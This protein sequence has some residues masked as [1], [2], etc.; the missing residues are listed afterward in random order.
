[1]PADP[2]LPSN[3]FKAAALFVVSL[4]D[5]EFDAVFL[6]LPF[7]TKKHSSVMCFPLSRPLALFKWYPSNSLSRF[8]ASSALNYTPT[9][10]NLYTAYLPRRRHG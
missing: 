2:I 10:F 7:I 6:S 3:T 8:L 9:P 1:M 4:S 5:C